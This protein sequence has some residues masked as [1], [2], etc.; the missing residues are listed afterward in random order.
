[1][2][3][4]TRTRNRSQ[5]AELCERAVDTTIAE[6]AYPDG[7]YDTWMLVPAGQRTRAEERQARL[8]ET[9]W[10]RGADPAVVANFV[11]ALS[12]YDRPRF[13]QVMS[14]AVDWLRTQ[15]RE[16]GTWWSER[17]RGP[18][19]PTFACI[20][21]IGLHGEDEHV[22][23]ARSFIL[24][25]QLPGSGWGVDEGCDPLS[26]S[27]ALLALT[28]DSVSPLVSEAR[29]ESACAF[30]ETS[31]RDERSGWGAVPWIEYDWNRARTE[32]P[33]KIAQFGSA[34]ITTAYVAKAAVALAAAGR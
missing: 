8:T 5:A 34:T 29:I 30:L 33:V 7:S 17:Y 9:H 11:Y 20:R 14:R 24:D 15:Q 6:N 3:V 13:A 1:M 22:S 4:V 32:Q 31:C 26:T 18:F 25:T 16:D 10:G 27:L 21:A 12:L 23:R 19:Y 2:Q 28:G